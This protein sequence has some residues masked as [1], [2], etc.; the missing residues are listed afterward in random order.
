LLLSDFPPWQTIYPWFAA[1][2]FEGVFGKLSDAPVVADSKRVGRQASATAAIID[3]RTGE[4][5]NAT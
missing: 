1:W 2:W 3:N 4:T 5:T